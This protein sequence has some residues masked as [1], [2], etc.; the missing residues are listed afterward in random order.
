[1]K[2]LPILQEL[3][4]SD[5]VIFLLIGLVV[6]AIV[7]IKLRDTN[8]RID[9]AG[10]ALLIYAICEV[11]SNLTNGYFAG[12]LLLFLGTVALGGF[13]GFAASCLFG[14]GDKEKVGK[15]KDDEQN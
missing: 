4:E 12:I 2:Y 13:I 1:M 3:F 7:G 14:H 6:S 9:C 10:T 11:L 8:K 15:D 5:S